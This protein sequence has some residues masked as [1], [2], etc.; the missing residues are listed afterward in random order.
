MSRPRA[1]LL[2]ALR[3]ESNGRDDLSPGSITS[4]DPQRQVAE[5][6][7]AG[8][9]PPDGRTAVEAAVPEVAEEL[10]EPAR[11]HDQP[12]VGWRCR[13]APDARQRL[14][15]DVV[16][17]R[18]DRRARARSTPRRR[19]AAWIAGRGAGG[20]GV[21]RGVLG[22]SGMS[23]TRIVAGARGRVRVVPQRAATS[24]GGARHADA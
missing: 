9:R 13:T 2:V 6:E 22:S 3:R 8:L 18:R 17:Q 1:L 12:T 19:A 7:L 23:S 14:V 4:C 20:V 11:R 21:R 15:Q 10:A 16:L 5:A 24:S